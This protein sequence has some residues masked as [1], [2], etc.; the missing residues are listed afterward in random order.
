MLSNK[1]C[2]FKDGITKKYRGGKRETNNRFS[3]SGDLVSFDK[4]NILILIKLTASRAFHGICF[5]FKCC[6]YRLTAGSGRKP[7]THVY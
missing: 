7:N 5:F 1:V 4:I 6:L 2:A 3:H